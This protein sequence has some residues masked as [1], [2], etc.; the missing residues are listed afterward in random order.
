MSLIWF[1]NK[2]RQKC[3]LGF[4]CT[5]QFSLQVSKWEHNTEE[6][7]FQPNKSSTLIAPY[8]LLD[9]CMFCTLRP[10]SVVNPISSFTFILFPLPPFSIPL[11]DS[12]LLF[13]VVEGYGVFLFISSFKENLFLIN[14]ELI[15]NKKWLKY[16][17]K[18][19]CKVLSTA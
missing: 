15:L 14:A 5:L 10:H 18:L 17:V 2:Y 13:H 12:L 7:T 16:G 6:P 8:I 11:L 3:T 9:G 19:N 4:V 1:D